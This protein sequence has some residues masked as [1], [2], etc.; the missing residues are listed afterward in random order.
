M[1][2]AELGRF[3]S[4]LGFKD[5]R[6]SDAEVFLKDVRAS[7]APVAVQF[8]RAET[9]AGTHHLHF[10]LMNALRSFE[11]GRNISKSLKVEVLLY[12]SGQRQISRAIEMLGLRDD[13]SKIA[14]MLISFSEKKVRDAENRVENVI[15]GRRDDSVLSVANERKVNDLMKT[16]RITKRELESVSCDRE[17][18][19]IIPWLIVERSALLTTKS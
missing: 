13:S 14:I 7:L 3:A 16:F 6:I 2:I 15:P 5:V 17:R 19:E 4:I 18:Q 10:A 1:I 12:A 8:F 9:I 11:L